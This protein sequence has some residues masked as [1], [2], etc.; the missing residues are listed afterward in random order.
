VNLGAISTYSAAIGVTR[1]CVEHGFGFRG[2]D[3]G[4]LVVGEMKLES[5][6]G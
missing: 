5:I 2:W 3:V 4:W 1:R 6:F